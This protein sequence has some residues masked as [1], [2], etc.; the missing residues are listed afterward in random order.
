MKRKRECNSTVSCDGRILS[1]Y[2][3][4]QWVPSIK[5]SIVTVVKF[6]VDYYQN[7]NYSP[8]A[9]AMRCQ[10]I[11]ELGWSS[12]SFDLPNPPCIEG[13]FCLLS[14]ALEFVNKQI[15]REAK[16]IHKSYPSTIDITTNE[17][18]SDYYTLYFNHTA[19]E[20]YDLFFVLDRKP[21]VVFEQ[22]APKINTLNQLIKWAKS[23]EFNRRKLYVANGLT[24]EAK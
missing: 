5:E 18:R 11:K 10:K 21:T 4:G 3:K 1:T 12:T 8:V 20:I 23:L 19:F 2:I 9:M 13:Q 16:R 7:F 6:P 22:V 24:W 14:K 17:Y 15:G